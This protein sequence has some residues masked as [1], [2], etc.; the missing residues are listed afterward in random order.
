M[1]DWAGPRRTLHPTRGLSI[2]ANFAP[3]ARS[4]QSSKAG[5]TYLSLI[6]TLN[7]QK[8]S[9]WQTMY[10]NHKLAPTMTNDCR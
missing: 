9:T 1:H 2:C 7:I 5:H 8:D 4:K 6:E 3:L 10:A